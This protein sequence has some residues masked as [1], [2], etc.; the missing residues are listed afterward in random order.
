MGLNY[1]SPPPACEAH[2]GNMGS[3]AAREETRQDSQTGNPYRVYHAYHPDG[4]QQGM[5]WTDIDEAPRRIMVKSARDRREQVVGDMTQLY[6][7]LT[8]WNRV[9]PTEEPIVLQT[10]VTP[11]VNER[12]AGPAEDAA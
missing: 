11:D 12:L 1:I 3:Q 2:P 6:L 10:D 7:D 9:N 5:L 4:Q 8:H